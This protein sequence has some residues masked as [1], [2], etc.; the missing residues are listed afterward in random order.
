MV[1]SYGFK[2]N[3]PTPSSLEVQ[4]LHATINQL[5]QLLRQLQ[6]ERQQAARRRL[7][8]MLLLAIP[9]SVGLHILLL[10]YLALLQRA[11]TPDP[12]EGPVTV[13]LARAPDEQLTALGDIDLN[14]L[15][16]L[17]T[18]DLS[19]EPLDMPMVQLEESPLGADLAPVDLS[20]IDVLGGSADSLSGEGTLSAAGGVTSYFGIT[21]RGTRFAYIVDRSGSMGEQQRMRIANAELARSIQALPDYAHFY[22]LYFSSNVVQPPMQRSWLAARSQ[23]VNTVVRWIQSID[24]GGGTLPRPA[25]EQ[26][27]ELD[28]LP[29]VIFFM[30]DGIIAPTSLTA[31]EVARMNRRGK[32]VVIH[33][34]AF[35]DRGSE[36]LLRRI[37][38]ESGG[39]YRFVPD[40][41][42]Q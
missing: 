3:Q 2:V 7:K 32:R 8:H 25:F 41:A 21:A 33:T 20:D 38:R 1:A 14:E 29:D 37:A 15:I 9:I 30:T 17:E 22:L 12:G 35:G 24:P 27:F 34:V 6:A 23:N 16:S 11:S 42:E 5:Q 19:A 40:G 39:T 31:E 28:V 4:Q 10:I 13:Q 36:E 18:A 26:V